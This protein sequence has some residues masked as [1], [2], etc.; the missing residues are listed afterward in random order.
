MAT[1]TCP[2]C[3][4]PDAVTLGIIGLSERK[5][6]DL[7]FDHDVHTNRDM[8]R[9]H[10]AGRCP[11]PAP[12]EPS[13]GATLDVGPTGGT[14]NTGTLTEP[15]T[16]D[17]WA[18]VFAQFGFDPAQFEIVNDTVR[19]STWQQSARSKD[20]DRDIVQL[21]SYRASFRRI[22]AAET[23]HLPVDHWRK[24]ILNTPPATKITGGTHTYVLCIADPQL[25]KKGTAEAVENWRGAVAAHVAHIR[26]RIHAGHTPAGVHVA[27]MGDE[28]EN[29][30][31]SYA[32][33]PHTVELNRSEQLELDFD[34]RV[35]TLKE[36]L[37]LGLPV[38]AS[39]VISNHGE[40]TRNGGKDPVTTRNDNSSTHVARQ[41]A[42]LFE[43]LEPHTGQHIDWTIGDDAPGVVVT[44]SG[45]P[46]Y[47]THGYIEKG[48]GGSTELRT[49]NAI[50]RQ[51]LGNT[52]T[53]G[54]VRVF[55]FAHYHHYY[56]LTF[57]G[58]TVLGCPALEAERSSEY[59]LHQF[60][61]WS[62]PGALGFVVGA[63]LP[64]GW[65]AAHVF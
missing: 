33:Q 12:L 40:Y 45:E 55:V 30:V 3:E 2:I 9:S 18:R 31:N 60:G 39:S 26:S 57:E 17:G 56:C 63:D 14:V 49:K 50:E 36:V 1:R 13:Q 41:V 35:W 64:M 20:G 29:V 27:F 38:T 21:Y 37:T 34:L 42:K 52:E 62:V 7:L 28:H 24:L 32:N 15:I 65:N 22:V 25:G 61:V 43:E 11:G 10:R 5:A 48:R 4:A 19:C 54:P 47:F 46:V 8:V 16:D 44:L 53:L 6:V 59:M 51:V 23:E 58:R